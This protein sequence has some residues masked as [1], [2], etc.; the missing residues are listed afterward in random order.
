MAFSRNENMGV[1][2]TDALNAE[3]QNA[4]GVSGLRALGISACVRMSR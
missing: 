3:D 2:S 1:L 4:S